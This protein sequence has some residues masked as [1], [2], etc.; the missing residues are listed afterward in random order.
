MRHAHKPGA[1]YYSLIQKIYIKPYKEDQ[2]AERDPLAFR[3][4]SRKDEEDPRIK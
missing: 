2:I 4:K 1:R 3:L